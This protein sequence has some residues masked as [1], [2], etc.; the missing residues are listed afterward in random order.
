VAKKLTKKELTVY[1]NILLERR[2][3]LTGTI[4]SI[5]GAYNSKD[6][7]RDSASGDE[8]DLGAENI[9]QEFAL[10]L[11]QNESGVVQKIDDALQRIEIRDFGFCTECEEPI[12]KERLKAIPWTKCCVECQRKAEML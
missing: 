8:A 5:G 2:G 1:K 4:D 12:A 9:A 6:G 10:S 3:M 11:L 7:E